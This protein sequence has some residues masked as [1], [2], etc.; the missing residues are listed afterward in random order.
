MPP[1]FEGLLDGPFGTVTVAGTDGN[2]EKYVSRHQYQ[3]LVFANPRQ[4]RS[5]IRIDPNQKQ[6][7]LK[8]YESPQPKNL[9][10]GQLAVNQQIAYPYVLTIPDQNVLFWNGTGY[11]VVAH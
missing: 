2:Q 5:S 3:Q 4:S 7:K 1:A 9:R 6:L 11:A 8:S 10:R